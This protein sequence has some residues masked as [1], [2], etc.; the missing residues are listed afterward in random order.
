MPHKR[1][2]VKAY[3]FIVILVGL[4]GLIDASFTYLQFS[5]NIYEMAILTFSIL[6]F[7]FNILAIAF[8]HAH[9][10]ERIVYV[11]PIYHL[12]AFVLFNALGFMIISRGWFSP[13]VLSGTIVVEYLSSLW[14]IT[15]AAY[16]VKRLS[17]R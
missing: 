5:N 11:L 4:L 16:L 6:F 15:F 2:F 8:F 13:A 3:L 9:G 12:L 17:L 14:E 7:F 1:G 10:T